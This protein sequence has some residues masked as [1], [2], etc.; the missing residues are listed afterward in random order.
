VLTSEQ[1]LKTKQKAIQ[2]LQVE[3]KRQQPEADKAEQ[4]EKEEERFGKK[5][6]NNVDLIPEDPKEE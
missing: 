2:D 6:Y 3:V 4:K 1:E 5:M